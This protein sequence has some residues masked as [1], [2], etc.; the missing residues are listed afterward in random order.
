M[1]VFCSQQLK[2]RSLLLLFQLLFL[3][4]QFLT[5]CVFCVFSAISLWFWFMSQESCV[6]CFAD[7]I[8]RLSKHYLLFAYQSLSSY[9][10][11]TLSTIHRDL[12]GKLREAL[13]PEGKKHKALKDL[14]GAAA[15][16]ALS[17]LFLSLAE[18]AAPYDTDLYYAMAES[19]CFVCLLVLSMWWPKDSA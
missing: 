17:D 10:T 18:A 12:Q 3:Y 1:S 4:R 2:G 8:T 14:E 6:T 13:G 19:K 11:L 15:R 9:K 7:T 5:Y 16:R